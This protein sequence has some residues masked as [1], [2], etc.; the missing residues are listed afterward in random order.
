MCNLPESTAQARYDVC[1]LRKKLKFL[2]DS[3]NYTFVAVDIDPSD[4]IKEMEEIT[5]SPG[6]EF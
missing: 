1:L 2:I 4:T 5:L 3:I 6:E